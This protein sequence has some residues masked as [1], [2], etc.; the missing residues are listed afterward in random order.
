V[1]SWSFVE[2]NFVQI[3]FLLPYTCRH[4]TC[5]LFDFITLTKFGERQK[6]DCCLYSQISLFK[7][8][9][10]YTQSEIFMVFCSSQFWYFKYIRTD[11]FFS[12][13]SRIPLSTTLLTINV[14]QSTCRPITGP[15]GSRTPT[16]LDIRD[17]K[18]VKSSALLTGRL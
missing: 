8:T 17:M 7:H 2:K 12:L 5:L 11:S 13:K 1:S 6:T 18:V 16:F 15:L 4:P 10:G 3:S 14:K 9:P